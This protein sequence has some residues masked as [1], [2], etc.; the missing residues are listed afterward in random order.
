MVAR[1]LLAC[2][3]A[4]TLVVAGCN[5]DGGPSPADSESD[6][7]PADEASQ[8]TVTPEMAEML[9]KADALDGQTDKVVTRCASC[10]L[11]MD[12]TKEYALRVGEYTMYVCQEDCKQ[13]F[14][15]DVAKS[16]MDMQVPSADE[17]G[18]P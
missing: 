18:E 8:V 2:F 17:S 4:G 15:K 7:D 11:G 14:G 13:A 5:Q 3:L 12:G 16:V 9:A 6:S 10:E 1:M